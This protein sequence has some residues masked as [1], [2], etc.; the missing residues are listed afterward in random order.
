MRTAKPPRRGFCRYR[1]IYLK[2]FNRFFQSFAGGEFGNFHCWNL[3]FRLGLRVDAFAS[4]AVGYSKSA[5]TGESYFIARVNHPGNFFHH[6]FNHHFHI[7][8]GLIVFNGNR[9]NEC[10]FVYIGHNSPAFLLAPW[11][12]LGILRGFIFLPRL[13]YSTIF[14]LNKANKLSTAPLEK[15]L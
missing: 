8:L 12:H 3:D 5:E 9:V 15:F 11:S 10:V 1:L 6:R 14:A 2:L 13:Y 4:R 7:L